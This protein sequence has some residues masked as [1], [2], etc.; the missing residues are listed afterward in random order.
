MPAVRGLPLLAAKARE[1]CSPRLRSPASTLPARCRNLAQGYSFLHRLLFCPHYILLPFPCQVKNPGRA[2]GACRAGPG[3]N[4]YRPWQAEP[5]PYCYR[6]C[7]PH[8]S[9]ID[10]TLR[11]LRGWEEAVAATHKGCG[12]RYT[13]NEEI[14]HSKV[15]CRI[16]CSIAWLASVTGHCPAKIPDTLIYGVRDRVLF[17]GS[18]WVQ[19]Q[20]AGE[21][22]R[23]SKVWCRISCSI[24]RQQVSPGTARRRSRTL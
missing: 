14:R 24:A 17:G 5:A 23:H 9:G 13:E 15:W 1:P 11:M 6:S 2:G 7:S 18:K 3:A 16:S 20:P 8:S 10:L 22:I 4:C 19:A 21:E 12:N